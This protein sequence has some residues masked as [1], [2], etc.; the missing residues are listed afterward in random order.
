MSVQTDQWRNI[1]KEI[2]WRNLPSIVQKGYHGGNFKVSIFVLLEAVYFYHQILQ[3]LQLQKFFQGG[4]SLAHIM[5]ANF[6]TSPVHTS[7]WSCHYHWGGQ[8]RQCP[9]PQ[10]RGCATTGAH[11][12]GD[13]RSSTRCLRVML[14]RSSRSLMAPLFF[15][16]FLGRG[17]LPYKL[18]LYLEIVRTVLLTLNHFS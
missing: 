17:T 4:P 1:V 8:G 5:G 13:R 2:M 9:C 16:F 6:A 3:K 15:F 11:W 14:H 12:A 7:L 18:C 10:S